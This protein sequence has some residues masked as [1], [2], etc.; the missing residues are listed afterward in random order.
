MQL[1]NTAFMCVHYVYPLCF[2]IVYALFIGNAQVRTL[3]YI[4]A[5]IN[6]FLFLNQIF[7][8]EIAGPGSRN[9]TAAKRYCIFILRF[10]VCFKGGFISPV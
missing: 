1:L 2:P 6:D 9:G 10:R 3:K 8:T 7:Q 5:M 4:L